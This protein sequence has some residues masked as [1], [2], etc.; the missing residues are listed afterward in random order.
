[1][2]K[3]LFGLL[4]LIPWFCWSQENFSERDQSPSF[5]S[6]PGEYS[7][8]EIDSLVAVPSLEHDNEKQTLTKPQA[9]QALY[10]M[11]KSEWVIAPVPFYNPSQQWGLALVAQYIFKHEESEHPSII[12]GGGMVTQK[13]SYGGGLG[14]MGHLG[15]DRWRIGVAAGKM[16][17]FTDFYGVGKNVP[18]HQSVELQQDVSFLRVQLITRLFSKLYGGLVVMA[19][20][21]N[22][23]FP[24]APQ[25]PS[26]VVEDKLNISTWTPGLKFEFDSR[27]NSFYPTQGGLFG[28][29]SFF[30]SKDFGDV[31][32]YQKYTVFYNRYFGLATDHVIAARVM[33]QIGSGRVPF[34]SLPMFGVQGDLR[35]FEAGKYRDKIMW[36]TQAEYRYRLTDRWGAVVFA[37]AGDVVHEGADLTL[38]NL[39]SSGGIGLRYKIAKEN[40]VDF[41]VDVA[42]GDDDTSW[43]FS[44]GQ[45]F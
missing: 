3:Y 12:A 37:G 33:S 19:F 17:M 43:Y 29:N 26:S 32:D 39:L 14:Y 28:L 10:R 40:P 22:N 25:I 24:Y 20:D 18:A 2:S 11:K 36:A 15:H 5:L 1:M 7:Y 27:D 31:R 38:N 9:F 23:S 45:A 16:R 13:K 21:L 6:Q 44:V 34:Y 42:Y 4:I 8:S 41:R 35:G 30:H